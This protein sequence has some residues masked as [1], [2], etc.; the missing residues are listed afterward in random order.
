[1]ARR[2]VLRRAVHHYPVAGGLGRLRHAVPLLE[3]DDWPGTVAQALC[4]LQ[5]RKG[6]SSQVA[7]FDATAEA[8]TCPKCRRWLLPKEA[9]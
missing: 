5:P 9:I 6:W 2:Y 8:V 1:V 4:G 3:P 7:P